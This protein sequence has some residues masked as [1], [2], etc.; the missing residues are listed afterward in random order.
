VWASWTRDAPAR[1]VDALLG[2]V[3]S[4]DVHDPGYPTEFVR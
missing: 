1:E 3:D 4:V 2:I